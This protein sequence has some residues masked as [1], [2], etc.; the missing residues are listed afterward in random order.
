MKF[1]HGGGIGKVFRARG[2][3][4]K[5]RGNIGRYPD[6]PMSGGEFTTMVPAG[7]KMPAFTAS[8]LE[9]VHYDNWIGPATKRPFN[10]NRF[11]YNWHWQFEYGGGDTANQGPHQ[12]DVARWGLNRDDG[13]VKVRSFGG[14]YAYKDSQQ[15][16]PN[17]QLSVF[18]YADGTILE[19]ETRGLPTNAEG[20]HMRGGRGGGNQ[21]LPKT[22]QELQERLQARGRS[23]GILIGDIFYGEK[24][25]LEI[26]DGGRWTAFDHDDKV[27]ADSNSIKEEESDARVQTG[28]GSGGH[29]GNFIAAVKSGKQS[30]LTCD[31]EEGF[32]STI[33]PLIANVSYRVGHELKWDG[34]KEQ[35][36]GDAAANKLLKRNDRKGFV[37]PNLGNGS[38]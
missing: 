6:G 12:F 22:E 14:L 13:P 32:R 24:G 10:P 9:K 29:Y 34:K 37:V 20:M 27:I 15:D 38:A 8:Y 31:I 25:R 21:A 26:D 23:S 3:C 33:L 28:S 35:F 7:Q 18:E 16:T 4:Y 5:R 17:E 30:D 2:L 19:F 1:I 36:V 11:H